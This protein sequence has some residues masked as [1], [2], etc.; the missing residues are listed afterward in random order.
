ML[1]HIIPAPFGSPGSLLWPGLKVIKWDHWG[2]KVRQGDAQRHYPDPAKSLM[3]LSSD[4]F[5]LWNGSL[6]SMEVE[7]MYSLRTS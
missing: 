4:P 2:A 5:L 6:Y 1:L 7:E 3:D